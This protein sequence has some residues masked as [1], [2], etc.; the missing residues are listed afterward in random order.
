M[1][2]YGTALEFPMTLADLWEMLDDAEEW[3]A[4]GLEDELPD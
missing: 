4:D 3:Y 2:G 1:G